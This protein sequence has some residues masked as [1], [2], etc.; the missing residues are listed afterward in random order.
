MNA[1]GDP[2]HH[3]KQQLDH[4]TH[5]TQLRNKG[6]IGYNGMAQ[7]HPKTAPYSSTINTPTNTPI[8]QLTPLTTQTASR[9]NQPFCHNTLYGQTETDRQTDRWSRRMFRNMNALLAML[10][11]SDALAIQLID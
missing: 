6:P 2:T 11:E 5:S 9:S 4:C 1:L 3:P 10:I 7:M 8:P